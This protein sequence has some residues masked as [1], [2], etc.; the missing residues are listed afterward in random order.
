[1]TGG[2][3]FGAVVIGAL[4]MSEFIAVGSTVGTAQTAFLKG[5]SASWNLYSLML[6][7]P[8]LRVFPGQEVSRTGRVH[9]FGGNRR[10]LRAECQ[11][12][13]VPDHDIRARRG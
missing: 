1:M 9:D 12:H 7:L 11:A 2:K 5:I 4:M 3:Q 10:Q 13:Y 6:A 8:Y